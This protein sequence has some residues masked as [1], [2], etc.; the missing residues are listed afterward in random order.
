MRY[1]LYI[2]IYTYIIYIMHD[3]DRLQRPLSL[4][5]TSVRLRN[6]ARFVGQINA[7]SLPR[8]KFIYRSTVI[9]QHLTICTHIIIIILF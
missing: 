4:R 9:M 2:Y 8:K 5:G 7:R 6:T 1:T 3:T